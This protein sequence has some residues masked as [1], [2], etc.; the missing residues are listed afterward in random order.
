MKERACL[1]VQFNYLSVQITY[2]VI[3][4]NWLGAICK[5]KK[6]LKSNTIVYFAAMYFPI[7]IYLLQVHRNTSFFACALYPFF[8][9]PLILFRIS[10]RDSIGSILKNFWFESISFNTD[11]INQFICFLICYC[12]NSIFCSVHSYFRKICFCFSAIVVN[13]RDSMSPSGKINLFIAT[14][15]VCIKANSFGFYGT[16]FLVEIK[17]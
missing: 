12:Y 8:L 1:C 14:I 7:G 4:E 2:Y 11:R 6:K 13:L 10:N 3:V 9:Y 17:P 16:F 15:K 5:N